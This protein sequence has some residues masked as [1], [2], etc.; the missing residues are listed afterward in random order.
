MV[1]NQRKSLNICLHWIQI[2]IE[3]PSANKSKICQIY[4]KNPVTAG[5]PVTMVNSGLPEPDQEK[6]YPVPVKPEPKVILK[7]PV[8][9]IPTGIGMIKFLFRFWHSIPIESKKYIRLYRNA[10]LLRNCQQEQSLSWRSYS[11]GR[12]PFCTSLKLSSCSCSWYCNHIKKS[13]ADL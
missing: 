11:L 12:L 10:S 4:G 8:P 7:I 2:R 5:I 9:A 6:K 13:S 1:P 3:G